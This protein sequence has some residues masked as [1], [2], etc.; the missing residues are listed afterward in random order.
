[1]AT[2]TQKTHTWTT[3][4]GAKKTS[5]NWLATYHDRSGERHRAT[6]KLK[7]DAQAWLDEQTAGLV[8]GQWANPRSGKQRFQDFADDWLDRQVHAASTAESYRGVLVNHVHPDLGRMQLDQITRQDIQRLVK[9]WVTSGA[10]ASTVSLRYTVISTA[11]RAAVTERRIPATPCVKI[12]LPRAKDPTALVPI[13]TATVVALRDAILPRYRALV[14][15]AAGTGM[16]RGELLGLTLDRVSPTFKTIR[17]DRQLVRDKGAE[18]VFGDLKTPSSNRTVPVA[19]VVLDA[20][21]AHV[22]T[23]GVHESGLIFTSGYGNPISTTTL[24]GA[25]RAAADAVGTD[26]TPHSLR[27]YFASVQI[28][29]GQSI[30]V[31]QGLLGHKSATETLDTYGHLMGDED[32]RSRSLVEDAL[33]TQAEPHVGQELKPGAPVAPR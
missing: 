12:T 9:S 2:I 32:D 25:W 8:T 19:Q 18:A 17:V 27:H 1:M 24:G 6:F 33:G 29:G 4:S 20:I 26:A 30:K 23:Y 13:D 11:F 14:T 5:K 15:V 31:L 16:R 7:R 10:A 28:R 3:K 21:T 22:S